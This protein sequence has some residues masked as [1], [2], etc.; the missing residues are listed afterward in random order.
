MIE[1]N[2]ITPPK[3]DSKHK[4]Q[5]I[6]KGALGAIPF[7][8]GLAG[9]T[10]DLVWK[11]GYEKRLDNWRI[12]VSEELSKK[13]D[14]TSITKLTENEEF[15]SLIAESTI[16]AL[17]NH[18]KL[19]LK[20]ILNLTINSTDSPVEYDFKKLFI[21][22][23]DQFTEYHLRT[24]GVIKENLSLI[25]SNK[26]LTYNEHMQFILNDVFHGDDELRTLVIEEL[27]VAKGL[28]TKKRESEKQNVEKYYAFTILG[29]KFVDLIYNFDTD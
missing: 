3:Q 17:K 10:F 21:N 16:I 7:A 11:S 2:N 23:I 22:Y 1:D 19:K 20:A 24:I 6:F 5:L 4:G 8:G 28:I 12:K 25:G 26:F 15:Q 18:Q 27:M 14:A 29:Q 13:Y 9:E